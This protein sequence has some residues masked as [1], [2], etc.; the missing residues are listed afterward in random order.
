M[1]KQISDAIE[2]LFDGLISILTYNNKKFIKTIELFE[3]E[4]KIDI[5]KVEKRV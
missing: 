4:A 1:Q 3:W 2:P 5:E